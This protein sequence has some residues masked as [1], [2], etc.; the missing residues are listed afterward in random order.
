MFKEHTAR[1]KMNRRLAKTI[2]VVKAAMSD[3]T[4]G[5]AVYYGDQI[6]VLTDAEAVD[7][8]NGIADT[9]EAA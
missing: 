8:L 9:M 1:H 3:G 7:L 5:V 4:P 2:R 6:V